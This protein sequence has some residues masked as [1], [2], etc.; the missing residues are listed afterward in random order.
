MSPTKSTK[1][2]FHNISSPPQADSVL[3][4][5]PYSFSPFFETLNPISSRYI[6]ENMD[7]IHELKDMPMDITNSTLVYM[8]HLEPLFHP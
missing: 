7:E 1:N 6:C 8:L 5:F 2:R 4:T 3:K